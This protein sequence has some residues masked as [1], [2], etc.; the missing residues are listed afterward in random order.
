MKLKDYIQGDR[1]GKEVNRL[2]RDAMNDPFLQDALEGF[3]AVAGDHTKTIERLEKRFAHPVTHD[4]KTDNVMEAHAMAAPQNKRQLFLYGSVAASI[5][6]LIG[7]G[8]FFLL[9]KNEMKQEPI[10][11][12]Q[13]DEKQMI[14][15]DETPLLQQEMEIEMEPNVM[16][17][18]PAPAVFKKEE[19]PTVQFQAVPNIEEMVEKAVDVT[20]ADRIQEEVVESIITEAQAVEAEDITFFVAAER[21]A[22]KVTTQ[23]SDMIDLSGTVVNEAGEPIS[24]VSIL[25]KG[26]AIGV[27][28]DID[29]VYNLQLSKDDS[30]NLMASYIG[31]ETKEIALADNHQTITLNESQ[32]SL[33]EVVVVGYGVQKTFREKEFQ[34]Y[35][36]Q[37]ADKNV[38]DGKKVSVRVTFFIDATGKPTEILCE[39]YTCENAKKEIENLLSSSPLWTTTNKKVTMTI[40]W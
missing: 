15:H 4:L 10:A 6:L 16:Q 12:I 11:M 38:C 31:Y 23:D 3:D 8:T 39:K 25:N 22:A 2:E 5:L 1:H 27:I 33:D 19:N 17:S 28:T 14:V 9:G 21:S 35:C 29:G 32:L 34:A 13:A 36:Q 37:K 26:T 30:I 7:F 20:A 24:G 40:R 18:P